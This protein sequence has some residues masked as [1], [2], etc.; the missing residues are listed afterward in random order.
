MRRLLVLEIVGRSNFGRP[1]RA[2]RDDRQPRAE[3]LGY[4]LLPLRGIHSLAARLS[5][6]DALSAC[7]WQ[8]FT[9]HLSPLPV[10]GVPAR[11]RSFS[12]VPSL[13]LLNIG[14]KEI[15]RNGQKSGGVVFAG[16]LFHGLQETELQRDRLSGNHGRSLN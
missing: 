8:A 15:D 5:P 12:L 1:F 3:A 14:R 11:S 10:P 2:R 7:S 9:F 16:N 6:F 4:V 13:R